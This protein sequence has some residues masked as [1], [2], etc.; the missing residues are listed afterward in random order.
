MWGR[1]SRPPRLIMESTAAKGPRTGTTRLVCT[2]SETKVR[3]DSKIALSHCQP[4]CFGQLPDCVEPFNHAIERFNAARALPAP[5]RRTRGTLQT[6]LRGLRFKGQS[7]G[8]YLCQVPSASTA[9]TVRPAVFAAPRF[10]ASRRVQ[11]WGGA[12]SFSASG[13]SH[14]SMPGQR[15]SDDPS[16]SRFNS[17]ISGQRD[18]RPSF[19]W[20]IDPSVSP[21]CTT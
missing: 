11:V 20:A 7:R 1:L 8:S 9:Q 15:L 17:S 14:N 4:L 3:G 2:A 6:A 18:A 19:R 10:R 16:W 21:S 5:D 13:G 12:Y